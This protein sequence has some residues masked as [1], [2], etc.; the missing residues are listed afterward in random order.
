MCPLVRRNF[1][2]TVLTLVLPLQAVAQVARS[3]RPTGI[4]IA[5]HGPTLVLSNNWIRVSGN[6]RQRHWSG[7][8][9]TSKMTDESITLPEAFTL[10]FQDGT[11]EKSSSM[12]I[13]APF[14]AWP[15]PAD[16]AAS[17]FA[18]RLP[19]TRVCT[20]FRDPSADTSHAVSVRWCGVLRH[21]S[22]YFRQ[23]VEQ[24]AAASPLALTR[25]Q[26]VQVT[27][28]Q[29]IVAGT[30]KGSPIVSGNFFLG[31]EHPL[32][33]S[34]IRAGVAV[35]FM[36]RILPL[37][38]HQTIR[39]SSVV[40]IAAP[41]QMRRAFLAYIERER[42]HPYRPFL[43]YN[44]WY[45][46]G[47][48]N[49]YG[50][51][52]ALDRIHAF[53][54]QLTRQ[55]GD[56]VRSFVFDDGWDNPKSLW[57]FDAGFPRGFRGVDAAAAQYGS[58][59]GVWLS[60]WGGYNR[61]K[62]DRIA[63]GRDH[64]DEIVRGGFALS[65]PNYFAAFQNICLEMVHRYGVNEFKFDGTGN[66]DTVF[67][68]SAFDS[69]FDAMIALIH[70]L[71]AVEPDIFINLTTG[72]Y[73]S[74]WWLFDSDA[75]WRGGED[76][77]FAGVGTARQ[78]WITYR[79]SQVYRNVVRAGP[80]FPLNSLMVHGMIDAHLAEGLSTDPGDDFRDEVESFFGSGT[81]VQEM[82]ITPSLL[83]RADWNML[84]KGAT[85]SLANASTL[86]DTHWIGG[87]PAKLQVYGWASWSPA[88]AIL[89]LRNPSDKP[90]TYA[91]DIRH[92]LELP[93]GAP[94]RYRAHDPW[95]KTGTPTILDARQIL[96]VHLAPWEVRTWDATP[97]SGT[98]PSAQ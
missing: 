78:R 86:R 38:P 92:V 28:P 21:G 64:G 81:Q 31:M 69:D 93:E 33:I 70:R 18:A 80:L 20:V 79:D 45:D 39:Y 75:I 14:T 98:S 74:P 26:L 59:I 94:L 68:G 63:Y 89:V 67:P 8:Q 66:A 97:I 9:I 53:G 62:L 22:A 15:L 85:W 16:P 52:A 41:G 13:A 19:G 10:T 25:V 58:H 50:E 96:T 48:N 17:R 46:L 44:S 72:T 55:R 90:L 6:I 36:P 29:V 65:G 49:R 91:L 43:Q 3:P 1:L 61:Q 23:I 24:R 54:N 27:N 4:S 32:S 60:P 5:I 40:G 35:A 83:T 57:G 37:Q 51:A 42:A 87:N 47:Y 11:I 56:K 30:V 88:K 2:L 73:P 84:A 7:L 34:T 71:R 82:Y 77:D 76:H 12:Q 95:N